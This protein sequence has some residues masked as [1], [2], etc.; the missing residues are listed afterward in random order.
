MFRYRRG[1]EEVAPCGA[2]TKIFRHT[3]LQKLLSCWEQLLDTQFRLLFA[4]RRVA[5]QTAV[6]RMQR[7]KFIFRHKGVP[8]LARLWLGQC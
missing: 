4:E 3:L 8:G 6:I 5:H 7:G 2:D 1:A